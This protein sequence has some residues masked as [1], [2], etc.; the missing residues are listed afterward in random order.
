MGISTMQHPLRL[1]SEQEAN[2]TR[3]SPPE[4]PGTQPSVSRLHSHIYTDGSK[5][6]D[7]VGAGIW[8]PLVQTNFRLPMH[9][10]VYN[11]EV[12]AILWAL[13]HAESKPEPKFII[14]TD[15]FSA[16]QAILSLNTTTNQLQGFIINKLYN[17]TKDLILCWVPAHSGIN[18][19]ES[20]D[21]LAKEASAVWDITHVP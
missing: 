11:A 6:D 7:C 1:G 20:A 18:G 3:N 14:Y 19:N 2:S 21:K 5:T 12:F 16:L 15:S 8:L 17:Y 13:Q 4:I 10:S 9:T